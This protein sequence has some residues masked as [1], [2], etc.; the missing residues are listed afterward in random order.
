MVRAE[1]LKQK[2]SF[3]KILL[4]LVPTITLLL[5]FVLMGGKYIQYGRYNWWYILILPGSLS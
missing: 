2:R 4:W 5:A 3:Q 1:H